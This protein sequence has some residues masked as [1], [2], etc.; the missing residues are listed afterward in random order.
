M[1]L[2]GAQITLVDLNKNA[3]D[4]AKKIFEKFKLYPTCQQGDIFR[5]PEHF[6]GKF[7]VSMSYGTIEHFMQPNLRQKSVD[8]H[9]KLLKNHG[10]SFMS[11]PNKLCPH[12]RLYSFIIT[13]AKLARG[14]LEKPFDSFELNSRAK[15]A[16]YRYHETFGTSI[17]EFDYLLPYLF[18][19]VQAQISTKFDNRYAHSLTLFA[20]K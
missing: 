10:L 7:D 16:G 1:G 2:Q 14:P 5:L 4:R 9:Y 6:S 8:T 12:Y 20:V 3:L 11:V 19:P 15:E 17:L 18:V 13:T